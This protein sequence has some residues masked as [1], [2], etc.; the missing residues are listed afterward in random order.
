MSVKPDTSADTP[1]PTHRSQSD[2]VETFSLLASHVCRFVD[3]WEADQAPPRI[4]DFL[5]ADPALRRIALIEIIKTDLEYRWV[6]HNVPKRLHEYR[7]EHAELSSEPLPADLIY[8]EFLARRASGLLVEPKEYLDE[9]PEQKSALQRLLGMTTDEYSSTMIVNRDDVLTLDAVDAGTTLGDFELLVGLGRGAFA[10]VFLA[11]QKSMQRLVAVKVSADSGTEPQTL[12]QLDHDY[13]VRVFDQRVLPENKLRLLYMQYVPGGTLHS[14]VKRVRETPP[15]ER[16]GKLLLAVVDAALEQ[17]GELRPNESPARKKLSAHT[18]AEAVA[19]LGARLAA[20]LHYAHGR[21]VLHRDIKP[22]NVLLTADGEPKLADFNISF[23]KEV[24]GATPAAYFGGSLA[25][26]SP[27][28]LEAFHPAL[29]RKPEE[30]DGRSDTYSLGVMLCELLTGARPFTD[31][32]ASGDWH[33]MLDRMIQSRLDTKLPVS[34]KLVRRG[35]EIPVDCP[36][37]LRRVL[38]RCLAPKP[39]D[40]WQTP[41]ELAQQLSVCLDPEA[42][43]LVDPP[44]HRPDT[45]RW[46]FAIPLLIAMMLVPSGIAGAYNW[47]YN[48]AVLRN[49]SNYNELKPKFDILVMIINAT[50]FP[51]G[52]AIGVWLA[53]RVVTAVKTVQRMRGGPKDDTFA[54]RKACLRLGEHA[55]IL[56]ITLWFVSGI[57]YPIFLDLLVGIPAGIYALFIGSLTICGLI[58][59][60]YPFFLVTYSTVHGLYPVFVQCGVCDQRDAIELRRMYNKVKLFVFGAALVPLTAI[61]GNLL[62]RQEQSDAQEMTMYVVCLGGIAAFMATYWYWRQL[63]THLTALERVISGQVG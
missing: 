56:S 52:V 62:L 53:T 2:A 54:L 7:S 27:E 42:R 33:G 43:N 13:I 14:V 26:M 31:E 39:E 25:Y 32:Q 3:A 5:P 30:L 10:K 17:R 48:H 60:V 8:E 23:S 1:D 51:L 61:L 34:M 6:Q 59:S 49:M 28:Q 22:A 36:A 44:S 18:W 16:T 45:W 47:I 20:A 55:A 37:S 19:W 63:E 15:K 21:G 11:R 35:A 58:A 46:K 9:F 41:G 24:S 57:T 4:Q 29:D 38:D 50:A 12:A 40:R